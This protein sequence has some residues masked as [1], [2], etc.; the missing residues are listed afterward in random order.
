MFL[1][2]KALP[3]LVLTSVYSFPSCPARL[4]SFRSSFPLCNL[5][6]FVFNSL[7]QSPLTF[8]VRETIRHD[9]IGWAWSCGINFR[10]YQRG[11]ILAIKESILHHLGLTF[12]VI[13]PRQS[14]KNELQAHL[15]SW[16]LFRFAD[17][18]GRIVSVSPTFKP[19]T[20]NNME[21]VSASLDKCVGSR[22]R[23]HTSKGYMY[24]LGRACVQF[25]SGDP[26][27]KVVGATADLL[28][29]VDEAQEVDP[30]KF[31]KDFDPM[32]ASTNATRV[33]WG[34]AWTS[35][36]LLERQRRIALQAQQQD[37]IQRLFFFT[38]DDV[39]RLVPAYG[40]H[41]D[42]VIAE[43]GRN[44]PLVRTQYFCETI[45]AQSGMFNPARLSLI[46]PSS[47]PGPLSSDPG[48]PSSVPSRGGFEP[49]SAVSAPRGAEA[50]SSPIAFLLDVAGMDESNTGLAASLLRE[51]LG[52]PGRDSTTL[53]IVRIDLSTIPTLTQPTYHVLARYAWTGENHLA[54]FG[55]IKNLAEQW[56]PQHIV[57]DATG[58]GEGLWSLLDH[59]FPTRVIPV[60]FTSQEKSEIGWRFLS[61][62]ETG[63]FI[64]PAPTDEVRLQYSRCINEILPGPAKRLR[65]GVPDGSRGPD[66]D[67]IHDD[68]I[69]AD[70]LTAVLDRLEWYVHTEITVSEGFNPLERIDGYESSNRFYVNRF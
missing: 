20:T 67:L 59:T 6:P 29:S 60:K 41:V 53:T 28:L 26:A 27:A 50:V 34:T 24:T 31:D 49:P 39:R 62:I 61:I 4:S 9:P 2:Q 38:A 56:S 18:G 52:N 11:V 46:F 42:R 3:C 25:F 30:A 68:Y 55:Q 47:V 33:F 54:V 40:A 58:V 8:R 15:F 43:R 44:H 21:R 19:Q 35:G 37:G 57:I 22:G 36:T 12:V 51:G 1:F 10:P 7:Y 70:S 14:G 32:T 23:W 63:R 64:D 65:W 48:L 16:L 5:V 66:G 45:D 17:I 13:F 69:L